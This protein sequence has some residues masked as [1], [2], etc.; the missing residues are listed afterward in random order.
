MSARPPSR[1][2]PN[3]KPP[4]DEDTT[5]PAQR[6]LRWA[7]DLLTRPIAIEK[8]HNQLHVV[9]I[10]P[11]RAPGADEPKSLSL[12]MR[13][14]LR[15]RL[16]VHD[17]ATQTVR[18]LYVVYKELGSNGWGGVEALP[19]QL[20]EKAV[21]EA[22]M[23]LNEDTSPLLEKLVARLREAH[24]AAVTHAAELLEA[25][26]ERWEA[27]AVPEVSETTHEEWELMERSWIGTV[28]SG[29]ELPERDR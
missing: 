7:K 12:Q 22:E 29:L 5:P 28:P 14:E 20:L 15:A 23:M 10:E 11:V 19:P 27:P 24:T 6:S 4:I 21:A 13:D 9:L 16:L 26:P 18:H 25:Q 17:P 8:R 2:A 3:T 1:V